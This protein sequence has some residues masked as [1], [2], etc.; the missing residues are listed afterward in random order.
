MKCRAIRVSSLHFSIALD[1]NSVPWSET[2]VSNRI[3]PF[4]VQR[5]GANSNLHLAATSSEGHV[6]R[7]QIKG[8]AQTLV[9]ETQPENFQSNVRYRRKQTNRAPHAMSGPCL[10]V[11]LTPIGSARLNLSASGCQAD[12]RHRET[13]V[14][15]VRAPLRHGLSAL[16]H[17]R[18]ANAL[19]LVVPLGGPRG[20]S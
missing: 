7:G 13:A 11:A 17:G 3:H 4:F 10:K 9:S 8:G 14:T 1:V 2:I 6:Y 5:L 15:D 20:I 12:E 16:Q 19:A 18:R